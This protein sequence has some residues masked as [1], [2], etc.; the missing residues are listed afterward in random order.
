MCHSVSPSLV[1]VTDEQT[2]VIEASPVGCAQ[3]CTAST[4]QGY[5]SD[6][7][8]LPQFNLR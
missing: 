2:E 1:H 6:P 4:W 5:N 3:G 8:L 7:A